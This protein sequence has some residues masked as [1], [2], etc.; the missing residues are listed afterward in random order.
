VSE[1]EEHSGNFSDPVSRVPMGFLQQAVEINPE[2][3]AAVQPWMAAL[4][5]ERPALPPRDFPLTEAEQEGVLPWLAWRLHEAGL[6]GAIGEAE[7][8]ARAVLNR[9]AAWLMFGEQELER[10]LDAADRAGVELVAIKGHAVGRTLYPGAPCRPTGDFDFLVAPGQAQA[11]RDMMAREGYR[12]YHWYIGHYWLACLSFHHIEDGRR[13]HAMDLHW[14]ITNRMY[15]RERVDLSAVVQRALEVPCGNRTIRVT[16]LIDSTIIACVHLAA[17]SPG[18]PVQMRWLLDVRLLL[19]VLSD[20]EIAVLVER[21]AAWAAV[22]AC[23]VFGEAAARLDDAPALQPA[24]DALR[25]AASE[26]RMAE[27]DRAMR[28]R[29]FDLWS[30]W[31]RL[32]LK[33][34]AMLPIEGARRMVRRQH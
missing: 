16:D 2:R 28:S 8:A 34:K 17:F 3:W 26:A 7:G 6:M 13:K 22:E 4:L 29:G 24:L 31:R 14:D 19:E 32:P 23:L 5:A 12:Q 15:F 33:G 11:A 9:C 18:T 25:A 30:Y 21:A 10:L 27:Y 1:K 20:D